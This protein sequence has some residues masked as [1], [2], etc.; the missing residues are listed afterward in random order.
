MSDR[1]DCAAAFAAVARRQPDHVA[2]IDEG[3]NVT[4][5][6]LQD[7]IE[8]RAAALLGAGL[9][10]GDR[11]ALVA[12][13]SAEFLATALAVWRS[14]GVLVTIYPSSARDDL[15][16]A[17]DSSDPVLVVASQGVDHDLLV[18][19]SKGTPVASLESFA[20]VKVRGDTA[21]NPA[22][23]RE[24]LSLICFSSGTTSRPKAIMLS[25]RAVQN[26]ADT[27][28][29]VWHFGPDD[30]GIVCLPMAWMYGLASTSL[31]LLLSG[32]TVIVVRRARPELLLEAIANGRATFL[33]GVTTTFTK[34]VHHLED[35][36]LDADALGSLRLC[37][38]GG[39]PRNEDAF[40]RWRRLS[41]VPVFDAYCSS[42]CLPLVTYDPWIDSEPVAGAA[43]RLVPR[44]RLK[45]V[46]RDGAE[47]PR[48]EV[49]EALSSGPGIMLGYWH[50]PDLTRE[51]LT[52]DGWYRTRDLVRVDHE[53]YV[54]VV[55]RLSDVIIRSGVN[56][57]PAEVER[58]VRLHPGVGEVAVL[59]LPDEIHGQRVVAAVVPRAMLDV[60]E[61]D[62]HVRGHLTGYKVPSEY[63]VVDSLPVNA[64]GKIDRRSLAAALEQEGRER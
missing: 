50:D 21:P 11:V 60:S 33:A 27:Y 31:A 59:G 41:G 2:L 16:Y 56:I 25:A 9:R 8:R 30:R 52:D 14:R 54:Y 37:V 20:P 29:E 24:P 10:S 49:G 36:S 40:E 26:C 3:R 23:L 39:E 7:E 62:Q 15:E 12:E 53:G 45:I 58:V 42:E 19:A 18:A 5:G 35:S 44:A 22:D 61:L 46:G 17:L 51:V 32:A 13:S 47:V 57:S 1:P 63:V 4:F 6:E 28:G 43:G 48:G 55:G 34:L 64:T 38:S